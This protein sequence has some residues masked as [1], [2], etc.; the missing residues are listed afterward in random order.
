MLVSRF[1]PL[2]LSIM[3]ISPSL[4]I[5]NLSDH[6]Q[7]CLDVYTTQMQD[8]FSSPILKQRILTLMSTSQSIR[9]NKCPFEGN[10]VVNAAPGSSG[11]TSLFL[12]AMM[13]NITSLH[14]M[15]LHVN[16]NLRHLMM[17]N[18]Q[19]IN[20]VTHIDQSLLAR[21]MSQFADIVHSP[22][23]LLDTPYSQFWIDYLVRCPQATFIYTDTPAAKW[24][25]A[26]KEHLSVGHVS[27]FRWDLTV[28]IPFLGRAQQDNDV[29]SIVSLL[30]ATREQALLSF[31]SYRT[32]VN[33]T[34]PAHQLTFVSLAALDTP[35]S[36]WEAF[37]DLSRAQVTPGLKQE[38]VDAG[39]PYMGTGG[40]II[41]NRT[42]CNNFE[43]NIHKLPG[44]CRSHVPST[45]VFENDWEIA[46]A[47]LRGTNHHSEHSGYL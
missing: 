22:V 5:C 39:S 8:I 11:T 20:Y 46:T 12:A 37:I 42:R 17:N 32:F 2:I 14:H 35:T 25:R 40:C 31:E 47:H 7:Q 27:H 34:I 21:H 6:Q 16:C 36:F 15:S 29:L 13:L 45:F 33:C 19:F 44:K 38:L 3:I 18:L 30:N 24:Y 41:G 26:R 1:I 28:P 43:E 4:I 10:V 23:M 9:D